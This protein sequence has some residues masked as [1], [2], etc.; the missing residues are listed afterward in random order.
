M[1]LLAPPEP[2]VEPHYRNIE[3]VKTGDREPVDQEDWSLSQ[4]QWEKMSL[5]WW[6]VADSNHIQ[7]S[8]GDTLRVPEGLLESEIYLEAQGIREEE[9]R[10]EGQ[11]EVG[12]VKEIDE[13]D[14]PVKCIAQ[15][16]PF[17]W[18][19]P[20]D[21]SDIDR[22]DR[23]DGEIEEAFGIENG[24]VGGEIKDTSTV[25]SN[26]D[27]VKRRDDLPEVCNL[28]KGYVTPA[29]NPNINNSRHPEK[30]V[31]RPAKPQPYNA[32]PQPIQQNHSA[33]PQGSFPPDLKLRGTCGS[34][35]EVQ[36]QHH[37]QEIK[38]KGKNDLPIVALAHE[39][40]Q[41]RGTY[42]NVPRTHNVDC[43]CKQIPNTCSVKEWSELVQKW[44]AK[45][46][47]ETANLPEAENNSK[48]KPTLVQGPATVEVVE[49]EELEPRFIRGTAM[50]RSHLNLPNKEV[51]FDLAPSR[52]IASPSSLSYTDSDDTS[53]RN[54][55]IR[56]EVSS[57]ELR[58][59]YE[60]DPMDLLTW[61]LQEVRLRPCKI[62]RRPAD[63]ANNGHICVS[64]PEILGMSLTPHSQ[65]TVDMRMLDGAEEERIAMKNQQTSRHDGKEDDVKE[66]IRNGMEA[67]KDKDPL[68]TQKGLI[69]P[70]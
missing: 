56:S 29:N 58:V 68:T 62:L 26:A 47:K 14:P 5:E 42:R 24:S 40:S 37:S 34:N 33:T 21:E 20:E 57:I 9:A 66:S 32:N 8:L 46:D 67:D 19:E 41:Q 52:L 7:Y 4:E 55:R 17:P 2:Y 53:L 63:N 50:S 49:E 11:Y 69:G 27:P 54:N 64:T 18:R 1:D 45:V 12:I 44:I 22:V 13:S 23:V 30:C 39:G 31:Q 28:S 60:S 35:L 70:T 15:R 59:D 51:P 36:D 25:E 38:S 16:H 6:K 3:R 65:Y 10:V 61:R 48:A 43:I